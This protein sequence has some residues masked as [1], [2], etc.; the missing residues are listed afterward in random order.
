MQALSV[1]AVRTPA[2]L[3]RLEIITVFADVPHC[4]FTLEPKPWCL[5]F[6]LTPS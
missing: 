6:F 1:F 5:S 3:A 2:D 4:N